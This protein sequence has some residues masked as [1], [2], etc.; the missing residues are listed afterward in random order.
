MRESKFRELMSDEF[1]ASYAPS[2]ARSHSIST[3]GGTA[4]ELIARGHPFREVWEGICADFDIPEERRWGIDP[5][6]QPTR[7]ATPA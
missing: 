1:G 2:V 5:K 4:E 6:A 3:L 7:G